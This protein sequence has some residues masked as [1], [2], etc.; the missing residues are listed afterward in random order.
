MLG[1]K[2][3]PSTLVL[4]PDEGTPRHVPLI[5]RELVGRVR[6]THEICRVAPSEGQPF[7]AGA[8]MMAENGGVWA[9]WEEASSE[10]HDSTA[11]QRLSR[12]DLIREITLTLSH[13][14]GNALVS[15]VT[16]RQL[17]EDRTNLESLLEMTKGDVIRLETLNRQ[18]GLMQTLHEIQP[19]ETDLRDLVQNLGLAPSPLVEIGPDPVKLRVARDLMKFGLRALIETISENRAPFGADELQLQLRSSGEGSGLTAL[20]SIKG[21]KLE[22]EGILPEQTGDSIPNQGRLSVFLAKEII[23]LHHGEIHAGPGL[24]GTEIL[25]S[26]RHL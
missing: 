11:R 15:L 14:L 6:K 17:G 18:L 1:A 13:E 5:V 9:C 8:G 10:V 21:H 2:Y 25:I 24:E 3:L 19:V 20:I 4:G 26:L 16:L 12:K 7:R 23:R 22:L